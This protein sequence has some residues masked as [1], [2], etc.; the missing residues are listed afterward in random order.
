ML[1]L[2]HGATAVI[3]LTVSML[4]PLSAHAVQPESG[5]WSFEG[6]L[7][8]KPGRG[9]QVDAQGGKQLIVTY[10]GYR[11]DGSSLFF[12][13]SGPRREDGTLV[14][15]L[16]EFEGGRPL[17]GPPSE[18]RVRKVLGKMS[19][20]FD[21][22]TTGIVLLPG[23][24]VTR[25]K[26]LQYEDL[27]ARLHKRRYVL[28]YTVDPVATAQNSY[29]NFLEVTDGKFHLER[30]AL[31]RTDYETELCDFRGTYELAGKGIRAEGTYKCHE[32][33][34]PARSASSGTF[35][36]ERMAVDE[37]GSYTAVIWRKPSDGSTPLA[38]YH[39]GVCIG[40]VMGYA[41]RCKD[42]P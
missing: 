32:R 30:D 27:T 15:D 10:F 1:R 11:E 28:S 3:A 29:A 13:A 9:L 40:T 20:S 34:N 16:V 35:H 8:G 26:R 41:A 6:E 19:I 23:E 17:S 7:S 38:E 14:A 39:S 5:M 18:G 31:T 21:S 2:I 42:T 12:Q 4:V 22:P 24:I 37:R 33:N 36:T 25:I